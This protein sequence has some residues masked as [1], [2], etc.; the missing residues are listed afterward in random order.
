[1]EADE[2]RLEQ[3]LY[4]LINNAFNN[5]GAGGTIIIRAINLDDNVR[6]EVSD[7]GSGIP[8]EEISRIWDRYYQADKSTAKTVGSGLGLAIVKAVLEAHGAAYGVESEKEIGTTFWFELK[9]VFK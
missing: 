4:N 5:T 6:I 7:S 2:A 8:E 9:Q 3:V 1:M